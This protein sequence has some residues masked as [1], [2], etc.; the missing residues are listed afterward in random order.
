MLGHIRFFKQT[1]SKKIVSNIYTTTK[2]AYITTEHFCSLE[3]SVAGINCH[4]IVTQVPKIFI[5]I[6]KLLTRE[7]NNKDNCIL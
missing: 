1:F 7:S 4:L 6:Y 3:A 5:L 2:P